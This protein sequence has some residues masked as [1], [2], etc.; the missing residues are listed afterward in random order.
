[1]TYDEHIMGDH[2]EEDAEMRKFLELQAKG[3]L[4]NPGLIVKDEP[5]RL[6][7]YS[8]IGIQAENRI[9]KIKIM[10][11]VT[12]TDREP[13]EVVTWTPLRKGDNIRNGVIIYG[14]NYIS[15]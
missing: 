5:G 2:G 4:T 12:E 11:V 13:A 3:T 10:K 1:M 8:T 7:Y 6:L 14:T 15:D 9:M